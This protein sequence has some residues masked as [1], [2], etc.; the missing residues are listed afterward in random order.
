[1]GYNYTII[2]VTSFKTLVNKAL[3]LKYIYFYFNYC[4]PYILYSIIINVYLSL[5]TLIFTQRQ[6]VL[7]PTTW[8]AFPAV[9]L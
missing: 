6:V 7:E 1:M 2:S 9:Y 8:M 4:S 3:S 5:I